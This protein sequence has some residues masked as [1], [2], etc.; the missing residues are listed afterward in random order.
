MKILHVIFS[1]QIG[2]AETM[3]VDILN[4]QVETSHSVAL[5]II[6]D[7][8]NPQLIN[9]INPKVKITKLA[10]KKGYNSLWVAAKMHLYLF[11]KKPDI[12]HFH[13]HTGIRFLLDRTQYRTVLTLH[14][15]GLDS[16]NWHKY[17]KLCAISKTVQEDVF[18]RSKIEAKLIYN[19]IHLEKIRKKITTEQHFRIVQVGRLDDEIKAQSVLIKAV[20][21]LQEQYPDIPISVDFIGGGA[22]L[23]LLRNLVVDLDVRNISFLGA[24]DREFIYK[25]LANYDLFVQPSNIE[26]FGLTIA[27]ALAANVKVLISNLEGPMEVV[28][29]GKYGTIF[30][31]GNF[32]DCARKI[33]DI[34]IDGKTQID[35][36]S[37]DNYITENF[38]IRRTA[39]NYIDLYE[40]IIA[41]S[42]KSV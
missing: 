11:K 39:S 2:G 4:E 29:G 8:Y 34:L 25:E 31:T 13:D 33:E 12:I 9:R 41:N 20:G 7:D 15:L 14:T 22:S 3:L 36:E 1:L 21:I 24:K 18:K 5:V 42:E 19:G 30:E 32:A 23:E 35:E 40:K 28:D 38:D 37:K 16:R 6:N 26:G 10:R 27:E 17:S